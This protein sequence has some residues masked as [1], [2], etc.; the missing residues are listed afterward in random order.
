MSNLINNLAGSGILTE[1]QLAEAKKW[2][3]VDRELTPGRPATADDLC[4]SIRS[5]V[6]SEELSIRET[7]L[8]IMRQYVR[9]AKAYTLHLETD[10]SAEVSLPVGVRIE[11]EYILPWRGETIR[12]L[13]L[14][15]KTYL[16]DGDR[17][18]YFHD[19]RE[20]WFGSSI[21]FLVCCGRPE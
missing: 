8:D 13:L 18:V 19:I 4:S 9:T 1:D 5:M 7:D 10:T 17:K 15:G 14:N 2:N 6:E 16:V 3:W 12:D 21:S 11:G 20:I